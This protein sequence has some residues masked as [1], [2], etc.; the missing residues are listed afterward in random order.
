MGGDARRLRRPGRGDAFAPE[1]SGRS[2]R[3]TV[4]INAL[5]ALDL[6]E[7]AVSGLEPNQEYQLWLVASPARNRA[8]ASSSLVPSAN[9]T[10]ASS[11]AVMKMTGMGAGSAAIRS[12]SSNPLI[13]SR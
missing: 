11:W 5:G 6:L 9:T 3:A 1:G 2:A 13:P 4:S 7:I 10:A 12:C 8:I